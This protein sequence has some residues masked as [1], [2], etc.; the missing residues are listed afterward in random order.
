MAAVCLIYDDSIPFTK[1][2]FD[3]IV[4]NRELLECSNNDALS[5]IDSIAQCTGIL[6]L[7]DSN[8]A[9]QRMIKTGYRCLQL[10]VKNTTVCDDNYT[11][12]NCIVV[13]VVKACH[14]IS[15][16]SNGVGLTGTGTMLYEIVMSSTIRFDMIDQFTHYIQ[17]MITWK[18]DFAADGF[19]CG[20]VR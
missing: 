12:E 15:R 2:G 1:S 18:D 11:V 8:D 4:D 17:L 9:T 7:V 14:T 13:F 20:T 19:P 16:P 5:I 10:L 3:F 6:F